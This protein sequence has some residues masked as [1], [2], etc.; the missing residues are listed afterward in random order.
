MPSLRSLLLLILAPLLLA[1]ACS[2]DSQGGDTGSSSS[3]SGGSVVEKNSGDCDTDAD[4]SGAKCVEVTPG[5]FRVCA[6]P[7][8]SAMGCKSTLDQC[9]SNENCLGDKKCFAK[10]GYCEAQGQYYNTCRS[11]ACATDA[12]C[13]FED[14]SQIC[15]PAGVLENGTSFCMDVLCKSDRECQA[16][17]GGKCAPIF[18]GWIGVYIGLACVYPSDGCR[19][20]KEC[21]STQSCKLVGQRTKCANGTFE[22]GQ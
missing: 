8:P 10:F 22:C 6:A 14:F 21:L 19:S 11:D 9:C 15:V 5:G 20:E 18:D 7:V 2:L 3:S 4:C 13:A 1:Q 12:D 17:P 16:E